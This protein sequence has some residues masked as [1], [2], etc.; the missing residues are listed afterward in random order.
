[1]IKVKMSYLIYGILVVISFNL[2]LFFSSVGK[3]KTISESSMYS[4][5]GKKNN[6]I[7]YKIKEEVK[8]LT[9][10][11]A[12]V[13]GTTTGSTGNTS[14]DESNIDGECQPYWELIKKYSQEQGVDPLWIC[15]MIANESAWDPKCRSSSDARGLMQIQGPTFLT[16]SP[17]GGDRYDPETNI[18]AGTKVFKG[19][20]K[21]AIKYVGDDLT[22]GPNGKTYHNGLLI[23][24]AGEGGYQAGNTREAETG[25]QRELKMYNAYVSGGIPIGKNLN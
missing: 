16:V 6:L 1:M 4:Y 11:T 24:G 8:E 7:N 25:Y 23:Y 5:T 22:S 21:A 15:A 17:E 9:Q 18:K 14:Y 12:G 3:S 2:I 13:D 20:L 10:S 19:A